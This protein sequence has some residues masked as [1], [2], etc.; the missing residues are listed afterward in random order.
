MGV[1]WLAAHSRPI[2]RPVAGHFKREIPFLYFIII[3]F[4]LVT[5]F[6]NYGVELT[7]ALHQ[8]LTKFL[9]LGQITFF[10]VFY[11]WLCVPICNHHLHGSKKQMLQRQQ[12]KCCDFRDEFPGF[13]PDH[14]FWC[15]FQ[16]CDS[17]AKMIDEYHNPS[18]GDHMRGLEFANVYP[19]WV[20]GTHLL[21][22]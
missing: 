20:L 16:L 12:I 10:G 19:V 9:N 18:F 2:L 6:P 17:T 21:S 7:N 22:Y 4:H 1:Q 13:W 15:Y 5:L 11:F 3:L 8:C 14:L